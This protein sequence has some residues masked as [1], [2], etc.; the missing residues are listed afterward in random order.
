MATALVIAN[1]A[2]RILGKLASGSSLS[3]S[4]Q[5]EALVALNALIGRWRNDKLLCYALQEETLTLTAAAASKTIGPSGDLNTTRPVDIEAAWIV[6]NGVTYPVKMIEENEYASI[7]TKT[8]AGDWP[9]KA[10]YRATM[11][12][13][14]LITWP[15]ANAT[16]TM[17]LRTRVVLA[18]FAAISDTVTL[19]PGWED[20]LAFNLA[21]VLAPEYEVAVTP[22]VEMQ[23]RASKA[24]LKT[25]NNRPMVRRSPLSRVIVPPVSDITTYPFR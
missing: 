5:A 21:V 12:A 4:E 9:N 11:P 8:L 6:D 7:V 10:L 23:A 2:A 17:K 19:P 24:A 20:A 3:T 13:G 22:E 14:T 25:I 18:E 16:R 15:V 1:R